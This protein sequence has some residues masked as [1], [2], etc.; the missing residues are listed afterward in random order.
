MNYETYEHIRSYC[1]DDLKAYI[2]TPNA[3][4]ALQLV[5]SLHGPAAAIMRDK[6][7]GL[8]LYEC[9]DLTP[10]E[11]AAAHLLAVISNHRAATWW[12]EPETPD[13]SDPAP[14]L[15][16]Q[17]LDDAWNQ[18]R[19]A[20]EK[21][22]VFLPEREAELMRRMAARPAAAPMMSSDETSSGA[23]VPIHNQLKNRS[24]ALAAVIEKA[25]QQ[26]VDSASWQSVWDALV[27]LAQSTD[28]PAPLLGYAEGE[29]VKYQTDKAENPVAF[30]TRGACRKRL[31]R[32]R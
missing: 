12:R 1:F 11:R 30:F 3:L 19:E 23:I 6:Q 21:F 7:H 25:K 2:G 17:Q 24:S 15:E 8:D 28:R 32:N 10:R 14:P 22:A 13:G 9:H 29:G 16:P 27:V 31:N 20:V 5:S 18:T 26:A 4:A